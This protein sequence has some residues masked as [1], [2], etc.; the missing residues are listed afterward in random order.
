MN[1]ELNKKYRIPICQKVKDKDTF[2]YIFDGK[3][4]EGKDIKLDSLLPI[5]L[6][7]TLIKLNNKEPKDIEPLIQKTIKESRD[8]VVAKNKI[9]PDTNKITPGTIFMNKLSQHI[10]NHLKKQKGGKPDEDV[11]TEK[12]DIELKDNYQDFLTE[13]D[14]IMKKSD[15]EQYSGPDMVAKR[16]NFTKN[17]EKGEDLI[18][19]DNSDQDKPDENFNSLVDKY[20]KL[21]GLYLGEII[22]LVKYLF[23]EKDNAQGTNLFLYCFEGKDETECKKETG[24]EPSYLFESVSELKKFTVNLIDV[25]DGKYRDDM[26]RIQ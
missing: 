17:C 9:T 14:E 13:L 5:Q 1:K 23:G 26:N 6:L 19:N 3:S 10:I 11:K 20:N 22:N 4:S 21:R 2:E 7:T 24:S 18:V 8:K 16:E 12:E 25:P 15:G